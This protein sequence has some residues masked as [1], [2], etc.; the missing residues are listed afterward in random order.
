M[1]L[2]YDEL[3]PTQSTTTSPPPDLLMR[4]RKASSTSEPPPMSAIPV[5]VC[6]TLSAVL[7]IEKYAYVLFTASA[8]DGTKA[9]EKRTVNKNN[10]E[11]VIFFISKNNDD[12]L[13]RQY[14]IGIFCQK[15]TF[16]C[17]YRIKV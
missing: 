3:H 5:D 7:P 8:V 17:I 6:V 11:R 2:L 1:Y 15:Y 10:N 13:I 9:A 12:F 16:F 14:N 4:K